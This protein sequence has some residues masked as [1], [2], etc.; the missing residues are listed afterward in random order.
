MTL[1]AF[2]RAYA[3]VNLCLFLGPTRADG[4]HELLT[5]FDSL[6][7]ADGLEVT[8]APSGDRVVCAGVRG[9]NLVADALA[10]LR[11]A[12]WDAPGLH[13]AIDKRIPVAAGMGGGSA[14]AA[15][16]LRLAPRVAAVDPDVLVEIA[17][18]LGADVPAQVDPGPSIGTGAGEVLQPLTALPPYA[19]LVLPQPFPLSTAAVYREADRLGRARTSDELSALRAELIAAVP[20]RLPDALI[21]NDLQPAAVS[22]APVIEH[23]LQAARD[24]GAD[25][26]LVCGSGPTVIGLYVGAGGLERAAA[27]VQTLRAS[28]P[29]ATV[30]GPVG[31][32]V[33][34]PT[35]NE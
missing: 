16:I 20:D 10:A 35:P 22:L 1:P 28:Y 4:R 8:P 11:A 30:A 27:A 14:D 6:T 5:L 29:R 33:L 7:L 9:P 13:V 21:V 26:A 18:G 3:K 2:E 15:A 24:A 12:G 34:D 17:A 23:A 19:V 25:R 32:G 31:R